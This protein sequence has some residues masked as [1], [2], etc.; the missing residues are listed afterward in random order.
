M[1]AILNDHLKSPWTALFLFPCALVNTS[2]LYNRVVVYVNAFPRRKHSDRPVSM[3]IPVKS[4]VGLPCAV[5]S[6]SLYPVSRRP[7]VAGRF[8]PQRQRNLPPRSFVQ[9][10]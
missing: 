6:Y 4:L 10:L 3:T 8:I 5:F 2:L 9:L 1:R 7:S